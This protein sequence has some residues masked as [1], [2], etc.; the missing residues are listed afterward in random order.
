MSNMFLI[1]EVSNI[2]SIC[3]LD[4]YK[5]IVKL[6]GVLMQW[7]CVFVPIVIIIFGVKD[8]Y[9]VIAGKG[10]DETLN[11][12]IKSI[13]IRIVAGVGIFLLPGIVTFVL[14]WVSTWSEYESSF[15]VCTKCVWN[16]D[17]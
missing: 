16:K 2:S 1:Q 3:T 5:T 8:L 14:S 4:S 10:T 12:S 9:N 13:V 6:I 15:D 11:K 7:I 17:C